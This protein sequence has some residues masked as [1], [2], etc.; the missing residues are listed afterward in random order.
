[1]FFD[2]LPAVVGIEIEAAFESLEDD[3]VILGP[4]IQGFAHLSRKADAPLI[5]DTMFVFT[6]KAGQGTL[7]I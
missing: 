7:K 1:M 6:F 4:G 2:N 3:K 5:I